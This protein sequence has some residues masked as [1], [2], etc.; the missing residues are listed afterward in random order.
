[1]QKVNRFEVKNVNKRAKFNKRIKKRNGLGD[2][3][4]FLIENLAKIISA[5]IH[6]VRIIKGKLKK[7]IEKLLLKIIK[8]VCGGIAQKMYKIV[9]VSKVINDCI[10][11][12]ILVRKGSRSNINEEISSVSI[13]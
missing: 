8:Y 7:S 12:K 3:F 13:Y 2:V 10:Q 6:K 11:E 9:K 1:M 5:E 4:L